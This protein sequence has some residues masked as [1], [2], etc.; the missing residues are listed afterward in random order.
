MQPQCLRRM[1]RRQLKKIQEDTALK[2]EQLQSKVEAE[3]A[4]KEYQIGLNQNFKR[5]S[6]ERANADRGIKPKKERSGYVVLSSRQKKY[7]Y[8]KSRDG[9]VWW[10]C[11]YGRQ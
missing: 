7:R 6:R 2:I 3:R 5:I 9:M 4:G 11:T 10:K 8:K 1:R